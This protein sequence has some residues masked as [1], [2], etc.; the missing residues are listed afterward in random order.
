MLPDHWHEGKI[1][2]KYTDG[3]EPAPLEV[4][5]DH[6]PPSFSDLG[7]SR[8]KA[9][10]EHMQGNR[11]LYTC[12]TLW[13]CL[14]RGWYARMVDSRVRFG[15]MVACFGL[16][17]A[18]VSYLSVGSWQQSWAWAFSVETF[19]SV[20]H[21]ERGGGHFGKK[22]VLDLLHLFAVLLAWVV[23]GAVNGF[24]VDKNVM[25]LHLLYHF[26]IV[27]AA[28]PFFFVTWV[29]CGRR[30]RSMIDAFVAF[31]PKEVIDVLEKKDSALLPSKGPKY[32]ISI[33]KHPGPDETCSVDQ[34]KLCE[35]LCETR[36]W[37]KK[38]VFGEE[39]RKRCH[40]FVEYRSETGW[41]K[42]VGGINEASTE[43]IFIFYGIP[44]YAR[45]S[46]MANSGHRGPSELIVGALNG[47]MF[48]IGYMASTL[49]ALHNV[50]TLC[51]LIS[52]IFSKNLN[53][54]QLLVL[55]IP[56]AGELPGFIWALFMRTWT[57]D[58]D[59]LL[60]IFSPS[61]V[62][63]SWHYED[64]P[65]RRVLVWAKA[66]SGFL[67]LMLSASSPFINLGQEHE[68]AGMSAFVVAA[69]LAFS[70]LDWRFLPL[71]WLCAGFVP[72]VWTL[73]STRSGNAFKDF[74]PVTVAGLDL[75]ASIIPLVSI[76]AAL[77]GARKGGL[78]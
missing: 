59:F 55:G 68:A 60:A 48:R 12:T 51:V 73:F 23:V 63:W 7:D 43:G 37:V 1:E 45:K 11:K 64:R 26:V 78:F 25:R 46:D 8:L 5:A 71:L 39:V 15:E 50:L 31:K 20:A 24:D 2:M 19:G 38:I 36:H 4:E 44:Y 21:T 10:E 47:S 30:S 65:K 58:A 61:H 34:G 22:T 77:A 6:T 53:T 35:K 42:S 75:M 33:T 54:I 69:T 18:G 32:Q 9:V 3:A 66:V 16:A 56:Q 49:G 76:S 62:L 41:F 67:T 74:I 72:E 14:L 52:G 27:R 29:T 17:V 28:V 57:W 13:D 40:R 70:V